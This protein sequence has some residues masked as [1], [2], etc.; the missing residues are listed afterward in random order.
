MAKPV[1]LPVW[2]T[3]TNLATGTES[4][5]T[6]KLE[7]SLG[8]KQQGFV[9][10]KYAPARWYN[11]LLN[12]IYT[13]VVYL[14]GLATD[15]QFLASNFAFTG[16][17]T[18]AGAETFNGTVECNSTIQMD[19]AATANSTLVVAGATTLNGAA[20]CN[21]GLSLGGANEAVFISAPVAEWRFVGLAHAVTDVAE[22][23]TSVYSRNVLTGITFRGAAGNSGAVQ[24]PLSLPYGTSFDSLRFGFRPTVDND[25]TITVW[26]VVPNTGTGGIASTTNLG[27]VTVT[28]GAALSTVSLALG[29]PEMVDNAG[30]TY[31]VLFDSGTQ[32]TSSSALLGW[33]QVHATNNWLTVK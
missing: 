28:A 21:A 4:G 7:P 20:L 15:A 31:T 6:V 30:A 12:L 19:G 2:G 3:D 24:L 17:N 11:W 25:S 27:S 26:K 29:A 1:T 9:P 16:A 5:Q 22:P 13:W 18:H 10:G 8:V 14:D 33:A 23:A 32:V